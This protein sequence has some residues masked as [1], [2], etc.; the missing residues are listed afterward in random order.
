MAVAGDSAICSLHIIAKS[1]GF[2]LK[3]NRIFV[4]PASLN[5]GQVRGGNRKIGIRV[6]IEVG[7]GSALSFRLSE[8]SLHFDVVT[9]G[10]LR[11]KGF[12]GLRKR[13]LCAQLG[14]HFCISVTIDT[15]GSQLN[16]VDHGAPSSLK[17]EDVR[18]KRPLTVPANYEG[19]SEGTKVGDVFVID[20]G[21]ASFEVIEKNGNDLRCKCTGPGLLLPRAKLSFWRDGKLVEKN[22]ELQTLSTKDWY[23]IEYGISEGV[24]FIAM[25]FNCLST[26]TSRSIRVLEK[27]ESLESLHKL[28]EIGFPFEQI[29]AVQ[30][31]I[32][33]ICGQLNKPVI[34]A[35]QLLESMIEYP[36]PTL[37]DVS[38]AVRQF[39]DAPMLS[40][41]SAVGPYGLKA[42]SVLQSTSSRMELWSREEDQQNGL[43]QCQLGQSLP[44]RIAILTIS[45]WML[46]LCTQSMIY[47]IPPLHNRPYSLIFAFTDNESTRM[48]LNLQWAVMPLLVDLSDDV[49]ANISK[50][51]DFMKTKGMV[52]EGDAVLLVSDVSPCSAASNVFQSIQVKNIVS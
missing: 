28:E 33:Y 14:L 51:T 21:M 27:I 40:G 18:I 35:S 20:G 47:G 26:K 32:T 13:S 48:V 38:E 50:T 45:V 10:E 5:V 16:V 34:V 3:K 15:E 11:E 52:E 39:A 31:K 7:T 30:E 22:Y 4:L 2:N 37:K 19:L 8:G 23:D 36:T 24:D 1:T 25:S 12:L 46:S 6:A 9:K 43:D 41:E 49:E 29:P 44:D 42:L 17:A